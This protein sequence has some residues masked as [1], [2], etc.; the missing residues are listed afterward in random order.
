MLAEIELR[1]KLRSFHRVHQGEIFPDPLLPSV[2]RQSLL[3][4]NNFTAE[5]SARLIK[6]ENAHEWS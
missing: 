6:S 4:S 3:A 1:N 2:H 5:I